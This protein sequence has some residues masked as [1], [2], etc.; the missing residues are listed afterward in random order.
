M[1]K[2]YPVPAGDP[3]GVF[4]DSVGMDVLDITRVL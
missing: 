1:M 2:R 4:G 3:G